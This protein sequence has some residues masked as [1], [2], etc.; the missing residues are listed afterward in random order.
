MVRWTKSN[1]LDQWDCEIG[2]QH[3]PY[4]G[5]VFYLYSSIHTFFERV[6]HKIFLLGYNVA[7][8]CASPRNLAFSLWEGGVWGRDYAFFQHFIIQLEDKQKVPPV[9][10]NCHWCNCIAHVHV[11]VCLLWPTT[12]CKFPFKCFMKTMV[13]C[14]SAQPCEGLLP[15]CS[16]ENYSSWTDLQHA[17]QRTSWQITMSLTRKTVSYR[18]RNYVQSHEVCFR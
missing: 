10:C 9:V 16:V 1:F 6:R 4:Y 13:T 11:H 8:V 18:C 5:K 7:K 3:F 12:S 14:T 2:T 17:W 15:D